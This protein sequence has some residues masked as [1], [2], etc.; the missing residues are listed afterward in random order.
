MM[1]D[2][3]ESSVLL[4]AHDR[5]DKSRGHHNNI[6]AGVPVLLLE[7]ILY[8]YI[9]DITPCGV[10]IRPKKHGTHGLFFIIL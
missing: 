4:S 1:D 7:I 5:H 3:S 6:D 9:L 2:I 10:S 8:G